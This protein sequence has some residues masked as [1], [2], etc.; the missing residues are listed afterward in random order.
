VAKNNG[1]R[2][3]KTVDR[4]RVIDLASKGLTREQIAAMCEISPATLKRR[5]DELIKT[6]HE[7]RNGSLMQKQFEVAQSGN[8]TMLIW[9]GKQYLGQSDKQELTGKDG[10]PFQ[11]FTN[12][13]LPNSEAK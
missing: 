2:P 12:V 9:L 4:S 8:P 13:Q 7:W 10:A 1:G 11:L 3:P 6:G 5:F